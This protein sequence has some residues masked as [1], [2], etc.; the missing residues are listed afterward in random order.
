M[1]IKKGVWIIFKANDSSSTGWEERRLMPN[2]GL[3]DIIREAHHTRT[4][5]RFL[6]TV[7]ARVE[8]FHKGKHRPSNW[9]IVDIKHFTSPDS[10]E[11]IVV[12]YC[13]Y[14][15]I[16]AEWQTVNRGKPVSEML[17]ALKVGQ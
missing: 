8:E 14:V 12:C 2:G 16:E 5:E 17:E 1:A 4:N 7:G 13:D 10:D 15:P 6:P 11:K 3:T 9:V